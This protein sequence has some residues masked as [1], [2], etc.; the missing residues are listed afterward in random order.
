MVELQKEGEHGEVDKQPHH[1]VK[2]G[3]EGTGSQSGVDI[4]FFE[5]EGDG[6]ANERGIQ[7]HNN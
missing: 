1:I 7:D 4:K 5:D 6:G 2:R 3:N